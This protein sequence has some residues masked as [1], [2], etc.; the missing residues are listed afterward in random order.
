MNFVE[1]KTSELISSALDY[2]VAVCEDNVPMNIYGNLI[3]EFIHKYSTD[4]EAGGPIK[5]REGIN[6]FRYNKIDPNEPDR[7]CAHKVVPRP[8]MEGSTN[9]VAIALDG[10]T[11]LI[12]AMRGYVASKL[13]DVVKIPQELL[14]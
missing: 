6:D 11:P 4:W 14:K 13:G 2:A 1:I 3:P 7:W 12:A 8:N 9:M 5:E 10:P